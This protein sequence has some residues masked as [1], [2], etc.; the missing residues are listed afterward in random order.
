MHKDIKRK[1]VLLKK[2][3]RATI[4]IQSRMR[5]FLA[6][7]HVEQRRELFNKSALIIQRYYRG[8]RCRMTAYVNWAKRRIF[9]FMKRLR[10]LKFKDI[11]IMV[12]QIR[13][14]F[15]RRLK[16]VTLIQKMVRGLLGRKSVFRYRLW[17]FIVK[18]STKVIQRYCYN[19]IKNI[20][21]EPKKVPSDN[22]ARR[23][24]SKKLAMLIYNMYTNKKYRQDL[25]DI[26]K[27]SALPLQRIIR[28]FLAR[29]GSLKVRHIRRALRKWCSSESKFRL[30]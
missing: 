26:T 23:Q 19:H 8:F 14:T 24:C 16:A 18:R 29:R 27:V 20:K 28:G 13:L 6:G 21:V 4:V 10:Y 12:M 7:K 9:A 11:A 22:W 15:L 3:L 25:N 5:V 2:R 30:I 1:S 17:L